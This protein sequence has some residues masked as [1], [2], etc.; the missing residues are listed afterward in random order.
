MKVDGLHVFGIYDLDDEKK[1]GEQNFCQILDFCNKNP[2]FD[3]ST[4]GK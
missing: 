4:F 1:T 2:C 3:I